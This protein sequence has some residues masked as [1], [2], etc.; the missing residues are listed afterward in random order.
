MDAQPAVDERVRGTLMAMSIDAEA[1]LREALTLPTGDRAEVAA[2]LLASLDEAALTGP[3]AVLAAWAEELSIG[4]AAPSPAKTP[5]RHGQR[6]EIDFARSPISEPV[7]SLLGRS[8]RRLGSAATWYDDQ[9]PGLGAAFIDA[10]DAA[11]VLLAT[12]PASGTPFEGIA[13]DLDVRQEPVA[14]FPY[15]LAYLVAGEHVHVLAVAHDH[16]RPGYWAERATPS[17]RGDAS[18]D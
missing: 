7:H 8:H 18:R 16:R 6:C 9:Q 15:H 14:R 12:W 1:V 13:P 4:R 10:V 3:D 5:G 11:I 2:E 17:R